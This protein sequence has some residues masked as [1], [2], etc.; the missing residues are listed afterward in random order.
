MK[1]IQQ[2]LQQGKEESARSHA[3][4]MRKKVETEKKVQQQQK[5]GRT[6]ELM[7]KVGPLIDGSSSR[8]ERAQRIERAGYPALAGLIGALPDTIRPQVR[9]RLEEYA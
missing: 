8:A 6:S 4:Y 7:D 1:R 2:R 9:A 5:G 3:E